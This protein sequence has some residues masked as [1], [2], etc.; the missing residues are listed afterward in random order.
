MGLEALFSAAASPA[1]PVALGILLY[2][3]AA[4]GWLMR[5]DGPM[6]L[7]WSAYA[8]ANCGFLWAALRAGHP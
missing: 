7:V 5:G 3:W 4:I 8:L 6:V 2:L 1:T